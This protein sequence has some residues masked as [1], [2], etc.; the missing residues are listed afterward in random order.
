MRPAKA[1]VKTVRTDSVKGGL[2]SE[3]GMM[4]GWLADVRYILRGWRRTPGFSTT[5][6]LTLIL[7]LALSSAIFAFADGYLF[8]PSPFPSA[9][10]LY[11]VTD[12]GN[13][14]AGLLTASDLAALRQSPISDFGFVEW[15]ISDRAVS[16]ILIDGERHIEVFAYEVSPGF[17]A[18][19]ELP[20]VAGRDFEDADHY[21][22]S[23]IPAWLSH[24]YWR[25]QFGSALAVIGRSYR[26]MG[27]N[28][29]SRMV[30]IVGILGSEVTSFDVNNEPPDLVVPSAG[31]SRP[32]RNL[33]ALPIVRLP[34]QITREQGEARIASVLQAVAPASDG[35]LREVRLRS[36]HESRVNGGRPTARVLFAGALLIL[37]L[38]SINLVYLLLTRGVARS[39]EIATRAALGASRWRLAR[40]F[41]TEG[42]LLGMIGTAGGLLLGV[43]L[44]NLIESHIPTFPT[45]GRNMA[46]VPML[47]DWR[48]VAFSVLLG[49]TVPLTGSVWPARRALRG[50]IAWTSRSAAGVV[51]ALPARL[52]RTILASE[53]AVATIVMIGTLFIGLGIWRYLHQPLGFDY[54]DRFRVTVT[55]N[56]GQVVTPSEVEAA[57]RAVG[58]ISGV[59]AVGPQR[60]VAIRGIE[61]PGRAVDAN[62]VGA[63]GTT[64]GYFETWRLR[65]HEGRWFVSQEFR[66]GEPV[67]VVDQKMARIAW[68]DREAL[69]QEIRV[70]GVLRRVVGIVEA[71]RASL[72][73]ETPGQVYVP[74]AHIPRWTSIVAWVPGASPA[75]LSQHV[76]TAVNTVV[77]GAEVQVKPVTLQDFFLREIGEAE[78]QAP[79]VAAFGALAFVL[80]GI[81]VFGLVSYL[82]EHRTRE[83]GIRL[84]LG[85]QPRDVW[86]SVIR[87]SVNPA[88]VGLVVGVAGAWTLESIVRST[89][90][91]WKSSGAVAVSI[92][93]LTLVA[94]ATLAAALPARRAMR[95]D[96]AVTLRME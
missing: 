3:A 79:I 88:L 55:R 71:R 89:V 68:P 14:P 28:G 18:T 87:Q 50:S 44:S 70:D 19:V 29:Q 11:F 94:V 38:A 66:D 62:S 20:L 76:R 52:S 7:A 40:L 16:G 6:I 42:L 82:V 59:R 45:S 23:H 74:L 92:V 57:A 46:L 31:Q 27:P 61:V 73:R 41:L 80:A 51:S 54:D 4:S 37:G 75:P 36:I 35:T 83:F 5:I 65:V 25:R 64:E 90:F 96:P 32:G 60:L 58:G 10:N 95:I 8:R 49:L 26:V 34:A 67:A 9:D 21:E 12:P 22:G 86:R 63:A 53:L 81:G 1:V 85:A 30:Q 72:S 39:G 91:G 17:R 33:L 47:Y 15:S 77:P 43:W 24:G 93:A 78:F 48:T 69:G 13:K 2:P 84:A 56:F